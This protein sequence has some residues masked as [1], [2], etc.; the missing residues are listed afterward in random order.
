MALPLIVKFFPPLDL[1]RKK[2]SRVRAK[3][4][5]SRDDRTYSTQYKGFC[6]FDAREKAP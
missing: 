3:V 2:L 4:E 5:K 1:R 6:Q